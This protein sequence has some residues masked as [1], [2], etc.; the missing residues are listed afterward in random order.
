M[1]TNYESL[2]CDLFRARVWGKTLVISMGV[3]NLQGPKSSSGSVK[4]NAV[5]VSVWESSGSLSVVFW[6]KKKGEKEKKHVELN[7]KNKTIK[8][9]ESQC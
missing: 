5:S 3:K 8:R 9:D 2:D 7:R 6:G 1:R 4:A